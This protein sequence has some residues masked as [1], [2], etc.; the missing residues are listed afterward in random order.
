LQ[1]DLAMSTALLQ[2][3][4]RVDDST[5]FGLLR[6]IGVGVGVVGETV[7]LRAAPGGWKNDG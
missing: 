3:C 2:V 5:A 4:W 1:P 6:W 7:V